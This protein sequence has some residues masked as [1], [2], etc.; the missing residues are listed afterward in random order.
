MSVTEFLAGVD[1]LLTHVHGLYPAD[2]VAGQLTGGGAPSAAPV[3]PNGTSALGG[4][5]STANTVYQRSQANVSGL[6]QELEQAAGQG[7]VIAAQG[8]AGSGAILEQARTFARSAGP[9]SNTGPGAQ[10]V[11]AMMDQHLQAIQ[12]Q[13]ERTSSANQ[14]VSSQLRA[15]ASGYQTVESADKIL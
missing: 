2:G 15:V 13:L 12:A 14:A 8:H 4:G 3:A 9:L 11:V 5:V 6:D 7:A 1:R 10:L